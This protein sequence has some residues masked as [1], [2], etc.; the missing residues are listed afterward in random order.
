MECDIVITNST[1]LIHYAQMMLNGCI[2]KIRRWYDSCIV[3]GLFIKGVYCVS[4]CTGNTFYCICREECDEVLAFAAFLHACI[5]Q[6][7]AT[8][9]PHVFGGRLSIF[10][11]WVRS[12]TVSR[13]NEGL[14][15]L[16][17]LWP[18]DAALWYHDAS[19][20]P[21]PYRQT[22]R[23]AKLWAVRNRTF[24]MAQQRNRYR[25]RSQTHLEIIPWMMATD[26]VIQSLNKM[27]GYVFHK[28]NEWSSSKWWNE[29]MGLSDS[30]IQRIIIIQMIQIW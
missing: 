28:Q 6:R 13:H 2:P 12:S 23:N 16:Q 19:H 26:T 17:V 3:H 20:Y 7:K 27:I 18:Y 14:T 15:G 30:L 21:T 11:S 24:I 22:N 5:A 25:I 10:C 1:K 4:I 8:S 9:Q 29:I